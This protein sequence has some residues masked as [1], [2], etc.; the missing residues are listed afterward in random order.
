MLYRIASQLINVHCEERLQHHFAPLHAY[1][2]EEEA[3][4][5]A[6]QIDLIRYVFPDRMIPRHTDDYSGFLTRK[7]SDPEKDDFIFCF[8]EGRLLYGMQKEPDGT[9]HVYIHSQA[10]ISCRTAIQYALL[11]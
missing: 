3:Q 4:H 1:M 10:S 6:V 2:V 5:E 7:S 11:L 8:R 9:Y